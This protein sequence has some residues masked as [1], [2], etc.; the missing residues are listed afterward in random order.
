MRVVEAF[1][2]Y[3]SVGGQLGDADLIRK[4]VTGMKGENEVSVRA[5]CSSDRIKVLLLECVRRT[6]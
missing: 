2:E 3:V 6:R 5:E 1:P 4:E